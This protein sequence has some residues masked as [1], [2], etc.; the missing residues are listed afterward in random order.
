MTVLSDDQRRRVRRAIGRLPYDATGRPAA[1]VTVDT[2]VKALEDLADWFEAAAQRG[3]QRDA[4]LGRL[5]LVLAGGRA[6]IAEL[7]PDLLPALAAITTPP[8]GLVF[9]RVDALPTP[10][11]APQEP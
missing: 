4:E 2:T 9:T 10:P 7:L 8:E 3:Q 6:F 11:D 1:D 5:R